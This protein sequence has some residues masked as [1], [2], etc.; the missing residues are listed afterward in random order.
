MKI[1]FPGRAAVVR[2][3]QRALGKTPDGVDGV[4]T[5]Q[6]IADALPLNPPVRVR[7]ATIEGEPRAALIERVQ[8]ALGG[9]AVDGHDGSETW[10]GLAQRFDPLMRMSGQPRLS[11][12]HPSAEAGLTRYPER[13]VQ[14]LNISRDRD[15][16]PRQNELAGIVLHHAAGYYDGTVSWCCNPASQVS[17]HAVV[18]LDGRRTQLAQDSHIAWHAGKSRWKGRNFC[19][20]FMLGIAVTGNTNDGAMRGTAGPDLTTPEIESVA[21]WIHTR[22]MRH[23]IGLQ[24]IVTHREIAP[25]R[26]DDTSDKALAAVK[27][28]LE[29]LLGL[30]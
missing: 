21:E 16:N 6:A 10:A 29:R 14:T 28:H 15:G 30:A 3:I 7:P 24:D 23:G 22:M 20:G 27:A 9:V 12:R 4:K 1:D 2:Q 5:W 11:P 8:R 19:N 13:L 18:A 17:Y 26:K 25:G